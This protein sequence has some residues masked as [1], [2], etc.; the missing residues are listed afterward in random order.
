M[1]GQETTVEPIIETEVWERAN[2]FLGNPKPKQ[3]VQLFAGFAFC[4]CGGKMIVPSNLAKY[5]CLNCRHKIP[6][7]DLEEVFVSQLNGFLI[8]IENGGE[9]EELNLADYWQYLNAK[10]RRIIIEQTLN[11]IIIGTTE[12]EIEFGFSPHSFK[13][14]AFGQ[15]NETS[16]ET[17]A[18]QP[19]ES[20]Q[21]NLTNQISEPLVSEAKAAEFL[22]I[23]KMTLLRKRNAG[24]IG[25][26]RVG[27][28]VLYSREKH[29]LP[30]LEQCEKRK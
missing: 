20:N 5:V 4:H 22:G 15:Q 16:N 26:F 6:T 29:L 19:K 28:R 23:S 7:D 3:S 14:A 8:S 2:N 12:I 11:K 9:S 18:T 17:Q 21:D 27:F 1:D 24:E 10:E 13:T 25:F 30:F